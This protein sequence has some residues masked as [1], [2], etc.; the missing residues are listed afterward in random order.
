MEEAVKKVSVTFFLT[1]GARGGKVYVPLFADWSSVLRLRFVGLYSPT[2]CT[3]PIEV[4][5]NEF[6]RH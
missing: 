2:C 4:T 6:T 5:A 3:I 1:V